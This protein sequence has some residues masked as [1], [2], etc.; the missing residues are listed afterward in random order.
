MSGGERQRLGLTRALIADRPL[1]PLDEP[2]AHL[3]APTAARVRADVLGPR[4]RRTAIVT[5]HRPEAFPG[6][7]PSSGCRRRMHRSASG[8][9]SP[10]GVAAADRSGRTAP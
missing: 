8:V 2:T 10:R 6:L 7:P 3:D 1:L 4:L 5:S 9:G